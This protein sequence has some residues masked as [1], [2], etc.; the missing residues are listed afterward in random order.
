M[1]IRLKAL[2]IDS[3]LTYLSVRFDTPG[4]A[5]QTSIDRTQSFISVIPVFDTVPSP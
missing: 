3:I 1:N 5:F 2:S 4:L